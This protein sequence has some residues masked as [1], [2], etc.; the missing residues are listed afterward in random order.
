[1]IVMIERE[2]LMAKNLKKKKSISMIGKQKHTYF[3]LG[4]R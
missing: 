3:L 2:I 1:M 4:L